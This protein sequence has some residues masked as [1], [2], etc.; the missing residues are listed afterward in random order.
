MNKH[1]LAKLCLDCSLS[2][3]N[4]KYHTRN[5]EMNMF[6]IQKIIETTFA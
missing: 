6:R 4:D 5:Q 3:E 2:G 1:L